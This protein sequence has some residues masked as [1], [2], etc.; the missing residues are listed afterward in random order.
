MG[1]NC[2][3]TLYKLQRT[4]RQAGSC[5]EALGTWLFNFKYAAGAGWE[6]LGS[7]WTAHHRKKCGRQRGKEPQLQRAMRFLGGGD[8]FGCRFNISL[9]FCS[10]HSAI[11]VGK[12]PKTSKVQQTWTTKTSQQIPDLGHSHANPTRQQIA[13]S[14]KFL[15]ACI[16]SMK[17]RF[18]SPD[19]ILLGRRALR[20]LILAPRKDVN[21]E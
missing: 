21:S 19:F 20:G 3:K 2:W 12:H 17:N 11:W 4:S 14:V 15:L 16:H 18:Q 9:T 8:T 13:L 1:G 6:G 7:G 5:T 10:E